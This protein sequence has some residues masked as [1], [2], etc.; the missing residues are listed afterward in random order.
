V[1]R[2]PI[3]FFLP[4]PV[5]VL[6]EIRR[7]MLRP[8]VAHRSAEFR[9]VWDAISAALPPVF[10][11][12]RPC[13]V[14]T[15]SSTLIMEAALVSFVERDVL[16]LVNGAFSERWLAIARSLGRQADEV[17]VPWG[18]AVTPDLLRAALRRKRYEAVTVVHNET[19]TGVLTPVAELARVAREESDALL[20]VDTVSSLAGAPVESDAWGLDLVVAGVQKGIAAPPGL[21]AFT[22][23]ER[24]ERRAEAIRHRGFYTDL[25]RYRDKQR[26]GGPITTPAVAE[27]YAL[28]KQLERIAAEGLEARWARHARLA[29]TTAVWAAAHGVGYPAAEPVRSPTVSCLRP[30][31]GIT[32]PDLVRALAGRGFTL[33]GGY[34]KWK[35]ETFRIGHMGEVNDD[36][37]AALLSA[38][39][40][41]MEE[42]ER[43]TG[44]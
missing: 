12:A 30:P 27:C 42:L 20:L 37:L 13:M 17:S 23:S 35:P 18:E 4:G 33:G 41:E 15:G 8:V 38:I 19:S 43:W 32:A 24:A 39:H 6:E 9:A 11:T 21:T 10:R 14:A 16:H 40:E 29:T 5:Y 3:R 2:E 36:D 44:S 28:A 26:E 1:S 34:G 25:L 7:E 31:R 22:F